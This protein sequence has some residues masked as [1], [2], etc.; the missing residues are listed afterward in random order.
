MSPGSHLSV[1]AF[2]SARKGTLPTRSRGWISS[3]CCQHSTTAVSLS[4]TESQ[5]C[6]HQQGLGLSREVQGGASS[7]TSSA[8]G[9]VAVPSNSPV[10][11][12]A[13]FTPTKQSLLALTS[14]TS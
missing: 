2:S 12:R 11:F 4:F 9:V 5:P 10:F 13:L 1:T 14:C 8:L 7:D 6:L 3:K